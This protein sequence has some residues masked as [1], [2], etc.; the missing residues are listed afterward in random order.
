MNPKL[1]AFAC[2]RISLVTSS[3]D[4]LFILDGIFYL[5]YN[6]TSVKE[7]EG[8]IPCTSY[9]KNPDGSTSIDEDTDTD[10]VYQPINVLTSKRKNRFIGD[11]ESANYQLDDTNLDSASVYLMEAIVDNV[12][13][14]ENIDF[15]V[16]RTKG[17]VTFN[18]TQYFIVN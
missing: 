8:T 4:T 5:E 16:D 18:E 3:Y 6:G 17:I 2:V 7:V 12:K 1:I 14:I 11:G 15:K 9:Y 10:L 13:M